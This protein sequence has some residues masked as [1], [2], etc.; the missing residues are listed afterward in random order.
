M[1][2]LAGPRYWGTEE[3]SRWPDRYRT[4]VLGDRGE[5]PLAG[6][7]HTGTGPTVLGDRGE[8]PV[9]GPVPDPRFW[10]TEER[11]SRWPDRYRTHVSGGQSRLEVPVAGPV[12]D[13]RYWGTEEIG[14]RWPD[15]YRTH[16]SGGQSRGP[17]G[18]T[19]TGPTVL[20]D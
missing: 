19:G 4:Q 18:W 5:V 3:R 16:V 20:G 2:P 11:G 10:G 17:G 6:P 13:P 9:A 8:V 1:V 7:V 14:C 15:R 12:P